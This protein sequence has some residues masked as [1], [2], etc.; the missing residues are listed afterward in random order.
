MTAGKVGA[1]ALRAGIELP[2]LRAA[3]E[4]VMSMPPDRQGISGSA[5][6]RVARLNLLRRAQFAVSAGRR[7]TADLRSA[8]S[9]GIPLSQAL[10]GG[11]TRERRYF[12]QH[13]LAIWQRQRAAAQAD[14]AAMTLGRLLGWHTVL[15]NHTSA[16]CRAA[17][18]KNFN[19][20]QMPLIGYP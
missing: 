10:L 8:R 9:R 15:D 20:D 7:I 5:T 1:L 13:I 3:I 19:V 6:G 17:N 2:A 18:G 16:E 14:S 4:V 12:G 11:I